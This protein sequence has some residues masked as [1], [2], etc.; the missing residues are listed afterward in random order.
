MTD[1]KKKNEEDE[2][3]IEIEG[4]E[5]PVEKKAE[6]KTDEPDIEVED[7]TPEIDRN[8]KPVPK[9]EVEKLDK[10]E[11]TEYEGK[12]KERLIKAKRIYHDERREKER[13]ARERDEALDY[14]RRI[15]EENKRLKSS[16]ETGQ[17]AI[18]ETHKS[19][20]TLEMEAAKRDFKEAY[21]AGD[22]DKMVAAQE[23][24]AAAGWKLGQVNSFRAPLQT[25]EK[26]I[27][28]KNDAPQAPRLDPKTV[29]WQA[30][31]TWWGSDEEMTALALGLH[32]KLEKANGKQF[33]G[34]D[35]YWAS[36]DE[37]MKRRFPEYFEEEKPEEAKGKAPST[38][39][40]K[41]ATVVAPA[42]RSTPSKKVVLKASQ[43]AIA[44]KLGLT[45]Q[46]Y[47]A[48]QQKLENN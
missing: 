14:A 40:T 24:I 36:I 6:A 43:L 41:P 35:E 18:I 31:N 17:K 48:A 33:V 45:P 29:A 46:Q 1:I 47:A 28:Q 25:E 26:E 7:D 13:A 19:A 38:N 44:K 21:E 34:T 8:R 2:F 20:A 30:K 3:E 39:G 32:Q 15:L 9:A 12:V 23:R 27:E 22:P 16:A 37:T 5:K 10:D 11:L 4:E 42:S